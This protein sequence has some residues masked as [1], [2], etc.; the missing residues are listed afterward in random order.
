M[1]GGNHAFASLS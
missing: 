1:I